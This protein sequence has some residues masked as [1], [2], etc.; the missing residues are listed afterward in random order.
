MPA[1]TGGHTGG[2]HD[3]SMRNEPLTVPFTRDVARDVSGFAIFCDGDEGAAHVI[4]H[5]MLDEDRAE[6]GQRLLG[7]WLEQRAGEGSGWVHLHWHMLV[8]ELAV[9]RWASARRRFDRHILSAAER[10]E[11]ATDAPS[12]LWRLRLAARQPVPLPWEPVCAV[13]RRE[14]ERRTVGGWCSVF[15]TLHHLL[16]LAGGGDV[17]SLDRWL[18][19]PSHLAKAPARALGSIA[20]GLRAYALDDPDDADAWLTAGL[21]DV[22]VLGGSRAQ[23]ALLFEIR[24]AARASAFG[25]QSGRAA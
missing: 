24:D 16:A 12:A 9:G 14:L 18:R 7:R 19:S 23:C 15:V 21:S 13:A 6:L 2:S 4:A 3:G 20:R 25:P 1:H 10:G 22:A 8:F 11:A 5:R 17:A